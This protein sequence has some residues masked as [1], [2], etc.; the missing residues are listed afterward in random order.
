MCAS[1]CDEMRKY[2]SS[3]VS[4]RQQQ[5]HQIVNL[6]QQKKVKKSRNKKNEK[7]REKETRKSKF[8]SLFVFLVLVLCVS[9]SQP[10]KREFFQIKRACENTNLARRK[11]FFSSSLLSGAE[12][13]RERERE[14]ERRS[15]ENK[16]RR[17]NETREPPEY[18]SSLFSSE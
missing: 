1:F 14:A 18:S 6:H 3:C 13:E 12:R 9:S 16:R 5:N 15:R 11:K 4:E 10:Q 8:L 7:R 2:L 17:E